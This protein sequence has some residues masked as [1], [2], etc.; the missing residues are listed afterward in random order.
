MTAATGRPLIAVWL[1]LLLLL[2]AGWPLVKTGITDQGNESSR[3]AAIESMVD[4]HTTAIDGSSFVTVDRGCVDGRWYSD[5][6]PLLTWAG[7]GVYA[8]GKWLFGWD[9]QHARSQSIWL[10]HSACW[11]FSVLTGFFSSFVLLRR[12]APAWNVWLVS[13]LATLPFFSTLAW[14]YSVTTGN[15]VPAAAVILLLAAQLDHRE[16]TCFRALLAGLTAGLLFQLEYV[17]GAVFGAALL[18]HLRLSYRDRQGTRRVLTAAGG[19]AAS[20]ILLGMLNFGNHGS[21]LPLYM[22]THHPVL[23]KDHL[24]YA[25]HTLFGFEGL[26]LYTPALLGI[27]WLRHDPDEVLRN[28]LLLAAGATALIYLAATS[29]FGGWCYGFRFFVSPSPLVMLYL[30]LHFGHRGGWP[31][32]LFAIAAGWGVIT[33]AI[34]T[35]NPWTPGYEGSRTEYPVDRQVRSA[36]PANLL[37]WSYEHAPDSLLCRFLMED[38]Y[39]LET[40]IPYLYEYYTSTGNAPLLERIKTAAAERLLTAPTT[41]PNKNDGDMTEK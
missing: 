37:A 16:M 33:A 29:D 34:G 3:F 9:F 30:I 38:F 11:L 35:I 21:W 7:A 26:F 31:R 10:I 19:L 41:L 13:G 1:G 32:R 17:P 6:P 40:A 36:L 18:L 20:L 4:R 8:I 25:F 39:G 12:R 14:S 5:K 28:R 27:F 15:H 23:A 22:E 24:F 2:A